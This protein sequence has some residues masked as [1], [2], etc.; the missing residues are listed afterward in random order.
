MTA[1]ENHNTLG[2]AKEVSSIRMNFLRSNMGQI[3]DVC[4]LRVGSKRVPILTT[5]ETGRGMQ[6]VAFNLHSGGFHMTKPP[7]GDPHLK[8][9][10][11][12]TVRLN[13]AALRMMNLDVQVER[14]KQGLEASIYWPSHWRALFAIPEYLKSFKEV[15]QGNEL[16]LVQYIK[17]CFGWGT[18]YKVS[19]LRRR[20]FFKS[21]F[22]RKSLVID[23]KE[24]CVAIVAPIFPDR[25]LLRIW[26]KGASLPMFL[27]RNLMAWKAEMDRQMELGI[28]H[29]APHHLKELEAGIIEVLPILE[30]FF[31]R[32]RVV[33][34]KPTS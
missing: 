2:G 26:G 9:N 19:V 11:G 24:D 34:W 13:L 25:P 8:D 7:G 4:W 10:T 28:E 33:S 14:F 18:W 6:V 16:D 12:K 23:P 31:D 17:A 20:T 15:I 3:K 27:P 29:M 21:N 32:F 30:D 22:G 1:V 5:K